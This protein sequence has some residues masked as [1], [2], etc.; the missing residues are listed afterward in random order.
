MKGKR[1]RLIEEAGGAGVLLS[2]TKQEPKSRCQVDCVTLQCLKG[3]G[4]E[5]LFFTYY[6]NSEER[7][8]A[9]LQCLCKVSGS[10]WERSWHGTTHRLRA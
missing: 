3:K 4:F 2:Q 7:L 1:G 6:M 8:S 10:R 5:D 9:Q